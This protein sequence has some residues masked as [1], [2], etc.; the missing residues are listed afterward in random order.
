MT[1]R[2]RIVLAFMCMIMCVFCIAGAAACDTTCANDAHEWGEWVV[3]T[4]PTCEEEGVQTRECSLCGE[5]EEKPVEAL[6]HTGG[7]ATCAHLAV[8]ERCGESYGELVAHTYDKQV[9]TEGYLATAATCTAP[10]KYYYSCKCGE[11][12]TETFEYGEPAA[13]TYDQ[14]VTTEEYLASAATETEPAKY[15]YSCICGEKGTETFEYGA[16]IGHT[17]AYDQEVATEEYLATAATCTKPATYYYSCECGAKGTETFE[18]G[19]PIAH[20]YDRKVATEEYLATAATCTK[21]ATY[22]YSCVCGEKGTETFEYGEPIAHTYDRQVATEEY[23]AT[24]ATC[25]KPATYYYSCVC[26]EKGTETFEY[27]EPIAHTYDQKVAT[28]EYLATA[29]TCT[30]AATYYNSC[31]CGAKG[32]T[33][34]EYGEPLGHD[35][36]EGVT[37]KP[38]CVAD[39]KTV[40]TCQRENCSA[41]RT[42]TIS[43]NGHSYIDTVVEPTCVANGYTLHK[44]KN[45]GDSYQDSQVKATGIH[46]WDGEVTC[47]TG[48]KCSVCGLTESGTGHNYVLIGQTAADCEHA[49][50]ETYQCSKCYDE[51]TDTI[52][53]ANG[54]DIEGVT[55]AERQVA[56]CKYVLVYI[57]NDCR[58]K[59]E[60]DT[61]YHHNYVAQVTTE[62]TC[63]ASGVKTITCSDCQYSYTE[64]ID[65]NNNAHRWDEGTVDGNKRTYKCLNG[66]EQTRTV[67]D[68]VSSEFAEG[69]NTDDLKETGE[70]QLSNAAIAFDETAADSIT[71]GE[72]ELSAEAL[73][74]DELED[75][76]NLKIT[77]EQLNQLGDSTV[78]NLSMTGADGAITNF[79]DGKVTVTIPYTLS[80]GED[81]DSIAIWYI[82]E[83]ELVSIPATYSNGY[84]TFETN[85]FSYYTVTRLTPAERCE[86]YGH[87][88]TETVVAPTCTAEGYTLKVCVRCHDTVKENIQPATGHS[89]KDNVTAATCVANGYILHTCESCGYSYRE[90][91]KATGHDWELTDSREATCEAAGYN[92]YACKNCGAVNT[93]IIAQLTHS[94]ESTVEPP[95]CEENGYTLHKCSVC[96]AE[97]TDDIVPAT[98]HDYKVE[99]QWAEDHLSATAVFTCANNAEHTFSEEAE[100]TARITQ[101]TCTTYGG[102]QYI[103]S[104]I[105]NGELYSDTYYIDRIE[106]LPHTYSEEYK[107]DGSSHWHVCTVCGAASEKEPHT[108]VDGTCSVCGGGCLH[109]LTVRV[110]INF[111]DYGMCGGSGVYYTC[112]CGEVKEFDMS[113]FAPQCQMAPAGEPT[114]DEDGTMHQTAVCP[115]CGMTAIGSVLMTTDGCTQITDVTYTFI[116][117][118]KVILEDVHSRTEYTYHQNTHEK[119]I[120]VSDCGTYFTARVC[121]NCGEIDSVI[122]GEYGCA[123]D[124]GKPDK[125]ETYTDENGL[126]HTVTYVTCPDCGTQYV[127]DMATDVKSVCEYTVYGLMT[128]YDAEG[129]QVFEYSQNM[130]YSNHQY[131]YEYELTGETCEDGYTIHAYCPVCG[132]DYDSEGKGHNTE[133]VEYNLSEY[134][135]CDGWGFAEVCEI[136]GEVVE[137]FVEDKCS[138]N[139]LG[140]NEDGY[141]QYECVVCHAQ[142][143]EKVDREDVDSCSYYNI[144][145]IIYIVNG[146]TVLTV[147]R[148]DLREEHTD[149]EYSYVLM[150]QTCEDGV[151]VTVICRACGYEETYNINHHEV[152]PSERINF[153]DYGACGGYIE[154]RQC[155][156]GQYKEFPRE[157]VC[158]F[159][160]TNSTITGEDGIERER[161]EFVCPDCGLHIISDH[162]SLKEGCTV[163]SYIEYNITIGEKTILANC[164][165]ALE[166]YE[167]HAYEYNYTLLGE[168]CED[169]VEVTEYCTV[170]GYSNSYTAYE[171]LYELVE[172]PLADYGMCGEAYLEEQVCAACGHVDYKNVMDFCDWEFTGYAEDG[173]S[174]EVCRTCGIIRH[175]LVERSDKDENCAFTETVYI[176]YIRDSEVVFEYTTIGHGVKHNMMTEYTLQG[177]SCEDGVWIVSTC[178][179]CGYVES[180]EIF[181]H[182]RQLREDYDL[183]EYGACGG[184]M[185]VYSCACGQY[186]NVELNTVCSMVHT[187][188]QYYD[189]NGNL[190][191]VEVRTCEQCGLRYSSSYYSV[192]DAE[193]CTETWY[194]TIAVSVKGAYVGSDLYT[195]TETYDSHNYEVVAK[196]ADGAQSCEDGVTI[197]YTCRDCGESHS[198]RYNHH[199]TYEKQII[200]LAQYGSV[201]GGYA[202]LMGCACGNEAYINLDNV[203]CEFDQESTD[204]WIE[205][206]LTGGQYIGNDYYSYSHYAYI[207]TCAVTDPEQCAFSIRY[208]RYCLPDGDGCV[209]YCYETW[210]FGYD[211]QTGECEYELT[212]KTGQAYACHNYGEPVTQTTVEDGYTVISEEL[213]CPDCGSYFISKDYY[214]VEGAL[215]KTVVESENTVIPGYASHVEVVRV[216]YFDNYWY[217]ELNY[218]VYDKGTENEYWTREE[219]SYDF[220][221]GCIRTCIYTD[222]YGAHDERVDTYHMNAYEIIKNPTCTQPGEERHYCPVCGEEFENGIIE[223]KD[224][225]WMLCENEDGTYYYECVTCG[226]QSQNGA[227]GTIIMEDLTEEAGENYVVGYYNRDEVE[228]TQYV[229]IIV[230]GEEIVLEGITITQLEDICAVSFSKSDVAAAAEAHGYAEGEYVVRFTFVP[231]G[232]DGSFDYSITFD[233]LAEEGAEPEQPEGEIVEEVPEEVVPAA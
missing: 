170:C 196:L 148:R 135:L 70:V 9:A 224:H 46:E 184:H 23:L 50:T 171:H 99:W 39:G 232:D 12:G 3:S 178:S 144:S 75:L 52:G 185:Y 127:T 32:E 66:C 45:C 117:G 214:D 210:Q 60:G 152:L 128:V 134:G 42:E 56:G 143:L 27:G 38:S 6:G 105:Y 62:A 107:S 1:G 123:V 194:Y 159:E 190:V 131:E 137:V 74:A 156:C 37:T 139:E 76:D 82:S 115:N 223:P 181:G 212:F 49:A 73:K 57:C 91:L 104:V 71:A 227:S 172:T 7:V 51:Y 69:I 10:A 147:D 59:V 47:T 168:T 176:S 150:G 8:C 142:K 189:D 219:Y 17:H 228:Y 221:G 88:Y 89:Y 193:T 96:G 122:G 25:T 103:A 36:D 129:E 43:A 31:S 180:Y 110:E 109:E 95:T 154:I 192:R 19:E 165:G 114:V 167:K 21:P 140:V 206:A 145:S 33:V 195:Y 68:A 100:V 187:N 55:P 67:I 41:T 13:H 106:M 26:G 14:K 125:T 11:K 141:T 158:E 54:H 218:Y 183:G 136:C 34:F 93:E 138:W 179:D 118:D 197:T 94:Y 229:S 116:M 201:C 44:C 18:Y 222:S 97:Y 35:W 164:K 126:E 160:K 231:Y 198:E 186:F 58:K 113:N 149:L 28:E 119:D 63:T 121:D 98:G 130:S 157:Y 81:V 84:V 90:T 65:A 101:P 61:V 78:Y 209:A 151:E 233:N 2:K 53:S 225:E 20:T 166:Q 211:R 132:D 174:V 162:Y 48:R 175:R 200:D 112:E 217:D 86:L 215:V 111:A 173:S 102:A 216:C 169:G 182:E 120:D 5:T 226:L 108:M 29:A 191:R 80:E 16:P 153:A 92:E 213:S 188:N 146:E 208:A 163:T 4:Q 205:G 85:H 161:I 83:D 124:M 203:M 207:Y 204:V 24:A 72:V 199:Y 77:E 177:E 220:E 79:G 133:H 40:Y 87:S 22:Y 230:N 30:A 15:Y 64:T 202:V 155:P